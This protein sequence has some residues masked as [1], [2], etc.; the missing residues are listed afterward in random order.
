M[1]VCGEGGGEEEEKEELY[2]TKDNIALG[3]VTTCMHLRAAGINQ[4]CGE[5]AAEIGLRNRAFLAREEGRNGGIIMLPGCVVWHLFCWQENTDG[6]RYWFAY[7][8]HADLV[9]TTFNRLRITI[10]AETKKCTGRTSQDAGHHHADSHL[11]LQS[12]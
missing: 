9:L 4:E 11:M 10:L 2:S 7:G 12:R 1:S 3:P 8:N 5:E 6:L